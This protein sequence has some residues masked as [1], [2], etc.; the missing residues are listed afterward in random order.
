[1]RRAL[2]AAVVMAGAG[3]AHADDAVQGPPINP[4]RC[5]GDAE[6]IARDLTVG[7][8]RVEIERRVSAPPD[9]DPPTVVAHEQCVIAELMKRVGDLDAADWYERAIATNPGEPGYELWYGSYLGGARGANGPI[10]EGAEK[11]YYRGIAK[12]EGRGPETAEFDKT[13][14]EWLQRRL[15][16]LYQRDGLPLVGWKAFKYEEGDLVRPGVAL[17]SVFQVSSDTRD[18]FYGNEMRAFTGEAAFAESS[19]RLGRP[20]TNTEKFNLIR[21]PLRTGWNN[22]VRFRHNWI[23]AIDLE[24]RWFQAKNAQIGIFTQPNDYVDIEVTELGAGF[25]R[26][27]PVGPLFDLDLAG[28]YRRTSRTGVVEYLPDEEQQFNTFEATP[29]L[30]RFVGPDKLTLRAAYVYMAIPDLE[31][32]MPYEQARGQTIRALHLEYAM[33]RKAPILSF[34][35]GRPHFDRKYTRG[36]HFYAGVAEDAQVYGLRQ[37][38]AR[39]H[40]LGTTLKGWGDYDVTLQGTLYT[41][42]TRFVDPEEPMGLESDPSQAH[43]Q[44]R[45]TFALARRLI[46]EDVTPGMPKSHLGFAPASLVLVMPFTHDLAVKGSN[47]F[48]NVRGGAELWLKLI[49]TGLGGATFLITGGYDY[50]FFY[51]QTKGAHMAHLAVRLGW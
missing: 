1:M 16:D 11:H 28:S 18:F 25:S 22:R 19:L 7:E 6:A 27:I 17:S 50:Q 42:G 20:L 12:L 49:G 34:A 33:Y 2:I 35:G 10:V 45:T 4:F 46:D 9:D 38:L 13:T 41:A 32:G 51:H 23:G 43:A 3:V 5:R 21:T 40:Y 44:Y 30:S 24:H 37:V 29:S 39:D 48:E 8:I 36:W 31:G 47:D 15:L 26:T 14:A